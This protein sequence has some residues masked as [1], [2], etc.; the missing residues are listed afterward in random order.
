MNKGFTLIEILVAVMIVTLLVTAA[1]P[2]YDRAV[3]KSRI[4]EV[5]ATLKQIAESKQ[6]IM[7]NMDV[8][9]Y[10][11]ASFGFSSLDMKIPCDGA[12]G[13]GT[14]IQTKNFKYTLYPSATNRNAVC[15][16][17]RSGD[18]KGVNFLFE[19]KTD[20]T[21][22]FLCNNGGVSGGCNAYGM[23]STGSSAYCS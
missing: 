5:R 8:T 17:R 11:S 19:L 4:A 18:N 10:S 12:C 22:R 9:D 13:T 1:V 7:D 2:I 16:V 14:T 21:T 3:E 15:A 6:R 23:S 20:G